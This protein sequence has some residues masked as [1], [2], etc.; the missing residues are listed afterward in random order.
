MNKHKFRIKSPFDGI[1]LVCNVY[2]P[3]VAPKGILQ[4]VHGMGEH[5]GR[6]QKMMEFFAERGYVVAIHDHRGHGETATTM[7]DRGW[8]NDKKANA[9]V[10]DVYAFTCELK[11]AYPGLPVYLYG[12]S[13][14]SMVVR[15]YIQNY[16]NE[17]EKLIVCGSPSSNPLAGFAVLIARTVGLIK[18]ER[19]RSE[20][21]AYISTG[22]GNKRFESEGKGG[23]LNRDRE[24]VE[25]YLSDP[26]CG[27]IFTCNGFENLF[28]L[29]KNTYTKRRYKV[30]NPNLPIRFVSGSDDPILVNENKWLQSHDFLREVG[31]HNV[32]GK[33]YHGLRHEIQNEPEK[34][35]VFQDLLQFIEE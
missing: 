33:L 32:S 4:L 16:D 12:H 13:M 8:F 24:N 34:E 28:R 1:E 21:L 18:G 7:E 25:A 22:K 26:Y 2:E 10:E 19:Y 14:G 23:W 29:M 20:T 3:D 35:M 17:I 31:Y 6:Y 30:E 27:F 9:V 11:R 15:C 5:S